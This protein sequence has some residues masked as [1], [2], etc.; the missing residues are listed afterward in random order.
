[1][2]EII[3]AV[4]PELI[5]GEIGSSTLLRKT[6]KAGNEVHLVTAHT[7]PNTMREIGRLR[8][9]SFRLGGGGCGEEID[10]DEFDFLPEPY[11]QLIVWN[12][13]AREIIGGYRFIQ[14]TKVQFDAD[15]QPHMAINH[16]F[17][18]SQEFISN[19]LPYTLEMGRAFVQ[20]KYQSVKGGLK[21]LFA[22]DNLWDGIGS[23]V[24]EMPHLRYLIGKVTIYSNTEVLARDA[25]VYYLNRYF[26]E[27]KSL[28]V[29]RDE[30]LPDL[31][32]NSQILQTINGDDYKSDF[33][34]LNSL[35]RGCNACVP[36]LIHAYIDLSPSLKTFGTVFDPSFGDIY[37]TGMMITL[38]DIYEIKRERYIATYL[39]NDLCNA[40]RNFV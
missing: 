13:D 16:I 17:T 36:P 39:K 37:D 11:G 40:L 5:E 32:R 38:A 35:V 20:P 24:A 3:E 21:S 15:G 1:M 2:K 4:R 29:P 30:Y 27:E 6:N 10:V 9:L 22:L 18:Q 14:G 34:S 8:E 26:R 33:K 25:M 12:P 23:L 7:A 31:S 28:L 19:Y